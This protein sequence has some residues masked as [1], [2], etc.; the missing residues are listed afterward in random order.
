MKITKRQLRQ[1][2]KEE[3]S[4]LK[5]S[6]SRRLRENVRSSAPLGQYA[7]YSRGEQ[8]VAFH[9]SVVDKLSAKHLQ[10]VRSADEAAQIVGDKDLV[11]WSGSHPSFTSGDDAWFV[12]TAVQ[13][14]MDDMVITAAYEDE[15]MDRFMEK[16]YEH[17]AR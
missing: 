5:R 14:A 2:I 17:S 13:A 16:G 15:L 9:S 12:Q 1:I 7:I 3:V 10:M 4:K 6:K 8:P 11:F